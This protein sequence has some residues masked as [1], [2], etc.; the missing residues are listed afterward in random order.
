[1]EGEDGDLNDLGRPDPAALQR[2]LI[3]PTEAARIFNPESPIEARLSRLVLDAAPGLDVT[4]WYGVVAGCREVGNFVTRAARE[5]GM[6]NFLVFPQVGVEAYRLDFVIAVRRLAAETGTAY[7]VF[8]I[9]ADGTE[10]HARR[11]S[12]DIERQRAIQRVTGWPV[13]RFSGA[14]IMYATQRVGDVLEAHVE[15]AC[16]DPDAEPDSPRDLTRAQLQRLVARLTL[17][18]ALRH[19]YVHPAAAEDLDRLR[20]LL[21]KLREA[22]GRAD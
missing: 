9:E 14:E 11:V 18:P 6:P 21:D 10:F 4:A 13:L 1:V 5:P 2:V 3:H 17:L 7:A 20:R 16:P 15:S 19:E 8:A 22:D 12:E